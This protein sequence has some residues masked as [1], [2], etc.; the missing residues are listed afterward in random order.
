MN[1][2]IVVEKKGIGRLHDLIEHLEEQLNFRSFSRFPRSGSLN[3]I[4]S[5]AVID[6]EMEK[7]SQV[8]LEMSEKQSQEA[9]ETL[10][11]LGFLRVVLKQYGPHP[12]RLGYTRLIS[13]N[14]RNDA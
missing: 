11:E 12:K 7:Y 6:S 8:F 14:L 5:N 3:Y 4:R 10:L 9:I 1:I 13:S 2:L